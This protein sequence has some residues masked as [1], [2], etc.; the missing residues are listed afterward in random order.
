MKT[1]YR[2]NSR[3]LV[4]SALAV[5]LALSSTAA[6]GRAMSGSEGD[7]DAPGK[8]EACSAIGCPNGNRQCGTVAGKIGAIVPPFTGEISVSWTCYEQGL[9]Q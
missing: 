9:A 5:V 6:L 7:E 2:L 8:S 4:S 3:T 1:T